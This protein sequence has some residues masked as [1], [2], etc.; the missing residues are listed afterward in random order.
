MPRNGHVVEIQSLEIPP[1][2][3]RDCTLMCFPLRARN[4]I[5]RTQCRSRF[6]SS[7][8]LLEKLESVLRD[9]RYGIRQMD[10]PHGDL[11]ET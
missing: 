4:C 6:L 7:R 11:P 10:S 5:S 1:R 3:D 9:N 8:R 2:N